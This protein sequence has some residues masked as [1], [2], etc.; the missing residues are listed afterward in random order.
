M[1][2]TFDVYTPTYIG[3]PKDT[4]L[5][6]PAVFMRSDTAGNDVYPTYKREGG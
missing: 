3:F 2:L 6:Y 5:S 1:R 4:A